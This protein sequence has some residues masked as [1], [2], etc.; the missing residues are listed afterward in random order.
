M[1]RVARDVV[2]DAY[3]TP[4]HD[5]RQVLRRRILWIALH[6]PQDFDAKSMDGGG[7][8]LNHCQLSGQH[9]DDDC[10]IP[11]RGELPMVRQ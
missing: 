7:A 4:Q 1:S 9:I 6:N 3:F 11:A 8:L 2:C 5:E 10:Q